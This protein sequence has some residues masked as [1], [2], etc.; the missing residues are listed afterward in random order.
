MQVIKEISL[1]VGHER[2]K[3]A[4]I[5][6]FEGSFSIFRYYHILFVLKY[7]VKA[8]SFNGK[9]QQ[10]GKFTYLIFFSHAKNVYY[11]IG[12]KCQIV[13]YYKYYK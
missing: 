7:C 3:V 11:I 4:S 12:L 9:I 13:K 8:V 5:V 1:K 10:T 2:A 6:V